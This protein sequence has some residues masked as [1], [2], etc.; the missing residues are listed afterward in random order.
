MKKLTLLIFFASALITS[1]NV[2]PQDD[3]EELY[4]VESYLV[5]NRQLPQVRLS[6]TIPADEVYD[7]EEAAVND[8]IIE[9][10]LLANGPESSVEQSF[11]YS[12]A[13]T[14]IYQPDQNHAVI[15]ERTYQLHISFPGSNDVITAHTIIPGSFEILGG[16]AESVVYQSTKQLEIT[17]SESSYPGRQNIFVFNAIS[18]EPDAE[19]LTPFY[20]DVFRDS[21][22]PEEDLTLLSNNSSGIINEGNFEVNPDGSVTVKYPWIGI[23]FYGVNDIVANTLDDN[24]YDFVRS[25]QV[26]LGGSTLSPGEIQNVI[27]HVDGGIGVFGSLASDTVTTN[28][29]RNPNL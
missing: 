10:R 2:Y 25:Q 3:Y 13:E 22:D 18:F 12:N 19:D 17:L 11:T 8:A 27:Y 26:Q 6:T 23:A 7:F 4:V 15:P 5:A 21:D 9:V 14:G 28:V 29:E 20:A 24:V 1:C 16:V